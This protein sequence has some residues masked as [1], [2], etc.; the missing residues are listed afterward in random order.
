MRDELIKIKDH[1]E[2]RRQASS[3]A[4]LNTDRKAL[5]K[6]LEER[7]RLMKIKKM[8]DEHEG[9]KDQMNKLAGDVALIKTM[10]LQLVESKR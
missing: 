5:D 7:E 9:M 1:P 10:L 3:K 2:L 8:A 4:V 6:Y